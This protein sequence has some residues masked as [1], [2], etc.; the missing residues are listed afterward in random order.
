[1]SPGPVPPAHAGHG[2][3]PG[4]DVL[5]EE[6]FMSVHHALPSTAALEIVRHP[7][8]TLVLSRE[9]PAALVE[10]RGE[11]DMASAP[12]LTDLVDTVLTR[13]APAVLVL[14]L[15]GVTFFCAAGV[16][17][18]FTARQRAASAGCMLVVREPSR[19]IRGI[20][21]LVGLTD[22]FTTE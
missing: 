16:T 5:T 22:E 3:H 13:H 14:D 19:I 12:L 1:M 11:V 21:D 6:R 4:P 18:L 7:I 2:H 20:L 10:A 8:L 9:G 15:S 17:A